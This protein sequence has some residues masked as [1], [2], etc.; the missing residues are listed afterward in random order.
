MKKILLLIA[1]TV[2]A[3]SSHAQVLYNVVCAGNSITAGV[4]TRTEA[5][6]YPLQLTRLLGSQY[7]VT[8]SGVGG[9]TTQDISS[10]YTTQ[11]GN[12]YDASKIN[13]LIILEVRNDL[14]VNNT[15]TQVVS[16]SSAYT[17]LTSLCSTARA[18]GWKIILVT[19]TPSWTAQYLNNTTVTGYNNLD[20]DRLTV[21]T[22]IMSGYSSIADGVYN[23]GANS[24]MGTLGQNAQ[25]GYVYSTGTRPTLNAY[26]H[27]GTHPNMAGYGLLAEGIRQAILKLVTVDYMDNVRPMWYHNPIDVTIPERKKYQDLKQAA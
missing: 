17:H 23:F 13:I 26:Y 5:L 8:N 20:A 19:V 1:I 6:P 27:D 24:L 18:Q 10:S 7:Q 9:Q 14:A 16:T 12:F 4:G 25:A 11:I 3:L 2:I 22:S 21:S 15:V